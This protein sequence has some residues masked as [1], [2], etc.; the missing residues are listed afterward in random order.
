MVNKRF[1][2]RTSDAATLVKE[3]AD[4]VDVVG[5][6]VK[7]RRVGNRYLGLCPFH[8]EKTPS[9]QVDAEN[10][11]YYCFGCGSGGD[12]LSFVMKSQ[13]IAF[14]EA[15][16]SLA[17]RY[18]VHLPEEEPSHAQR[19]AKREADG[20]YLVLEAANQFFT[21][22][23]HHSPA[24]ELARRT[25]EQRGLPARVVE[26]QRL[27][28]APNRWDGLLQ[29]LRQSGLDPQ[30]G[31]K[32]G[33]LVISAGE[34]LYDRFRHRLIFPITNDRGKVVAFGGR[35]LDGSDP[36]Y[37]NSPE[38]ALY[39]KGRMLYNLGRAREAC[40]Q[41]RQVVLV[42]G[43]M[44]LL[45]FHCQ[46]FYRVVATL[47]TA[48]T[49][50]QVRLLARLADEVV[51]L[52]DADAAGE[53][54]MI[55]ALPLFLQERLAVTCPKLPAG[56]D[57]DDFLKAEGLEG[58]DRILRD[59]QDLGQVAVEQILAGWDG[60]TAGKTTIIDELQPLLDAVQQPVLYDEYLRLAGGR[61]ALSAAVI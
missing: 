29:H 46:G 27:G 59:R 19:E 60:T 22:Q 9:F 31:V 35:S 57:P 42:E 11:L 7:L 49:A 43:Y 52:Y 25:I 10:Q 40:R 1:S 54:A 21:G 36:K 55:R 13:N 14:G 32:A 26:E 28:Y 47:G 17:E 20:L 33:L 30:L 5:Q 50:Q 53:R 34:R 44:D 6:V 8:Q 56:M 23:L 48:L 16:Q 41:T 39:H 4:I 51:L 37:L 24:G 38:T 45:A 58:L 2:T 18:H 61:L 3:A 12:I 15:L